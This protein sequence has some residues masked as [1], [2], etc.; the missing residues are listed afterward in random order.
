MGDLVAHAGPGAIE[1][2][3]DRGDPGEAAFDHDDFKLGEAGEDAFGDQGDREVLLRE[4]DVVLLLDVE[5][6]P[7]R[8]GRR[9]AVIAGGV[10]ADGEVVAGG[11]FVDRP[12]AAAAEGFDGVGGHRD[13]REVGVPRPVLDFR[14]RGGGVLAGDDDGG[15]EALVLPGPVFV[16]PRVD[17][18][19]EGL[20]EFLIALVHALG[21][22]QMEQGVF[23]VVGVEQLRLE[24][25]EVGSR[26]AAVGGPAIGAGQ[27]GGDLGVGRGGVEGDG[28]AEAVAVEMVAPALGEIGIE[29]AVGFERVV[30]VAVDQL[31]AG[32]R[33]AFESRGGGLAAV[34]GGHGVVSLR[35]G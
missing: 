23:D 14:D 35:R 17:G 22:Q 30:N 8:R 19:T 24:E 15:F 10:Q 20:A 4:G 21:R 9:V 5:R 11:G 33:G 25:G 3:G 31:D 34:V 18:A 13:L 2:P 32:G 12:V 26:G 6:R 29:V 7:A 27:S 28:L 16:L 1:A